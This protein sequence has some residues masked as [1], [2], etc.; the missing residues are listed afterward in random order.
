M[1]GNI[2]AVDGGGLDV[3]R[4]RQSNHIFTSQEDKGDGKRTSIWV[5]SD[6]EVV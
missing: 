2:I 3:I 6:C 1:V 4:T 5:E